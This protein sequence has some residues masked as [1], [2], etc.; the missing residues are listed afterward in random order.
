MLVKNGSN[1]I[2]VHPCH[3]QPIN[4]IPKIPEIP[5][6]LEI[7]KT[8]T[9]EAQENEQKHYRQ[10]LNNKQSHWVLDT[11][12][13]KNEEQENNHNDH[14]VETAQPQNIEEDTATTN[15]AYP[16]F[17]R[18]PQQNNKN[19][20]KKLVKL[21]AKAK[22]KYKVNKNDNLQSA[23]IISTVG[24]SSG[25]NQNWWNVENLLGNQQS[26]Q[27]ENIHHFELQDTND[28]TNDPE[29]LEQM[30]RLSLENTPKSVETS[31]D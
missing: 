18:P 14:N 27:F 17:E 8:P 20:K 11:S 15:Q 24:K 26:L 1:Y 5:K 19:L 21:R 23:E 3:L 2:W 30:S 12:D 9:T 25:K 7:P 6:N 16:E 10:L 31:Q 29:I 28:T 13:S 22:I 4:E